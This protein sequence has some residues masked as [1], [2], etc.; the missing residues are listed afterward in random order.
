MFNTE[1]SPITDDRTLFHPAGL[2]C[3]LLQSPALK[4]WLWSNVSKKEM[5]IAKRFSSFNPRLAAGD[6]SIRFAAGRICPIGEL[7]SRWSVPTRHLA[8]RGLRLRY[9]T[10]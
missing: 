9:D 3:F 10:T 1:T 8:L 6:K 5:L 7:A 2:D 4:H